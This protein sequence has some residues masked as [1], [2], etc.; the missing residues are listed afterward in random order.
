MLRMGE[1]TVAIRNCR[2]SNPFLSSLSLASYLTRSQ[3]LLVRLPR[4]REFTFNSAFLFQQSGFV[5]LPLGTLQLNFRG[6]LLRQ[7][8]LRLQLGDFV[9]GNF[10]G[11]G[12]VRRRGFLLAA[13]VWVCGGRG[14]R[15]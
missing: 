7:R 5:V 3:L 6:L 8:Q 4:P 2:P 13:G 11:F 1:E 15:V 9:F 14:R 10:A 12:D